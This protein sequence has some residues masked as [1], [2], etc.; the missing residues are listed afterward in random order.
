[1][2]FI[3]FIVTYLYLRLV[4]LPQLKKRQVEEDSNIVYLPQAVDANWNKIECAL[5]EK[6]FNTLH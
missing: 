1:M 4:F 2:R 3:R 5:Y 6:Q